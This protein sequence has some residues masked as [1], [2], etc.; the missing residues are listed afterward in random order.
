[1]KPESLMRSVAEAFEKSD[2]R[3]LLNAIDDK[4]VWKSA[5]TLAGIVEHQC[6]FD[7]AGLLLQQGQLA[8]N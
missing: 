1:M 5:A 7:T 6:F 4:C 3:P 8:Q 2:L